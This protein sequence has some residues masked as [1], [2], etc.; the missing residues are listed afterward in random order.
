MT[1]A[2]S[3]AGRSARRGG[4]SAEKQVLAAIERYAATGAAWLRRIE[5]PCAYA[6]GGAVHHIEGAGCDFVGLLRGGRHVAIEVKST[7]RPSMPLEAH[8]KPTL[9]AVQR[10]ELSWCSALGGLGLILIRTSLRWWAC[11]LA[12]WDTMLALCAETGAASLSHAL[13]G[14]YATDCGYPD[15][16]PR[17][18]EG[19]T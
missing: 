7:G 16:R 13:L 4:L 12:T 1:A 3:A 6:R 18:L 2:S 5:T 11:D 10:V 15:G 14:E 8:G 19:R 17:F 9:S